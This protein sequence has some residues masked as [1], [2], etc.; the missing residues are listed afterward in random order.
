MF[1]AKFFTNC[2]ESA[3]CRLAQ[4]AGFHS[5]SATM[6]SGIPMN[7]SASI[8]ALSC[9]SVRYVPGSIREEC[10]RSI[11]LRR[12]TPPPMPEKAG[13]ETVK[14]WT[15]CN[16]FAINQNQSSTKRSHRKTETVNLWSKRK[17]HE[18]NS[19]LMSDFLRTSRLLK[20]MPNSRRNS[21]ETEEFGKIKGGAQQR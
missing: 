1:P 9:S 15:A 19:L 4:S 10:A 3:A 7:A 17:P 6:D 16:L 18:I 21:L 8:P 14:L 5:V 2:I 13:C 12:G 11:R 20:K